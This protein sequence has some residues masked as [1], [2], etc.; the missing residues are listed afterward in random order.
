M[1]RTRVTTRLQDIDKM[2]LMWEAQTR[3][4]LFAMLCYNALTL[5]YNIALYRLDRTLVLR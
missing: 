3:D 1:L 2:F 4:S 5:H